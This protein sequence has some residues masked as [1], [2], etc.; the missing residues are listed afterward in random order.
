MIFIT[1]P[2]FSGKKTYI[3]DLYQLTE[4]ELASRAALEVQELAA[5]RTGAELEI[6]AEQL[7]EK[8]FVTASETGCGVVPADPEERAKREAA[9]RLACLLAERAD[10]V[11]RMCCGI[12]EALKGEEL[13]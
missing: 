5:G 2:R 9:G 10:I 7:S 13:Y 3:K 4:K 11:I 12:P 8:E 1:G 6:L